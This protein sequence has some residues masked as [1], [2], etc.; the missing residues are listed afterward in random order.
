MAAETIDI[1]VIGYNEERFLSRCLESARIA[2]ER[3][4][5]ACQVACETTYVDSHSTDRSVAIA[6]AAG[7]SVRFAPAEF[8]TPPNGRMAGLLQTSGDYIM[9]LDGDM[10]LKPDFLV[11]AL[12]FMREH[13]RAAGLRGVWDDLQYRGETPVLVPNIDKVPDTATSKNAYF[14]GAF[15]ARRAAIEEVGGY[16]ICLPIQEEVT[17][18]CKLK[19]AGWDVYRIPVPMIT[20]YNAKI[21]SVKGT[22]THMLIGPK[23][24]MTGA[25]LRYAVIHTRWWPTLLDYQRPQ[26]IH[27][28]MLA[29]FAVLIVWFV[30]D[31]ANRLGIGTGISALFVIYVIALVRE[32]RSLGRG[33]AALVLRT[34]YFANLCGSFLFY[35]PNA[36]FGFQNTDEYRQMVMEANAESAHGET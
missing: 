14:A 8:R 35:Y 17:L 1:I 13:P 15:F 10:E 3:L 12:Q 23:P 30:C 28:G 4:E 25:L 22:I 5:Q 32:K 29:L 18:Y 26:I 21:A 34:F 31:N 20:H 24:M 2:A 11:E 27:G 16:E 6:K 7:A 19:Q 33:L 36:A 9:F